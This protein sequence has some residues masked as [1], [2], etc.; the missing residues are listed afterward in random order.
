MRRCLT[1]LALALALAGCGGGEI[2]SRQTGVSAASALTGPAELL[3]LE[4][5][6]GRTELFREVAR[7][8]LSQQGRKATGP[9]LFPVVHDGE[10]VAAPGFDPRADLFLSADSG[11]PLQLTFD[12][13]RDRWSEERRDL[14]QGLSEREAAELVARSLLNTWG[15][16]PSGPVVVDR[17]SGAPYAAAYIDG[18]LRINPV[19][20]YMAASAL[21]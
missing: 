11:Q 3:E 20:L 4:T 15:I 14:L 6:Q 1:A 18:N 10:V 21:Q 12:G 16:R 7:G 5:S 17:A 2:S 8:S 9:V 13:R 19:F